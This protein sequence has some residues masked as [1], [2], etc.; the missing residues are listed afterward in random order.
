MAEKVELDIDLASVL[1]DLKEVREE[2]KRVGVTNKEAFDTGAAQGYADALDD[3]RKEYGGLKQSATT[4]KNA[5]KGATD[6]ALIKLYTEALAKLEAGMKKLE[7]TGKAAGVSLKEASKSAGTGKQVFEGLVGAITK[8]TV[9]L[10]VIEGVVKFTK[11]AVG[12]AENT[13]LA[14]KQFEA[15]TG[16][17][18]KANK[19]VGTLTSVANKNFLP[20]DDVL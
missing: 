13:K 19:I 6:P 17:A 18:E 3:L 2:L 1:K 15:F 7:T 12:L 20:V 14:S 4:L 8:A 9:I 10:A 5:L 11:Y 16:S